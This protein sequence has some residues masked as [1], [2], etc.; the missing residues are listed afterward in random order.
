MKRYI[1]PFEKLEVWQLSLELSKK[2][3]LLTAN[4]SPDER[5]G[6]V[7]QIRRAAN[8]VGA[9]IAEGATRLS[10]K[11]RARFLEIA[12]GS[13]MEV[14][15]FLFLSEGLKLVEKDNAVE[16]FTLIEKLSN[17]M[18]AFHK[19]ILSAVEEK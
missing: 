8:S 6:I 7:R 13:L 11:D 2:V 1:F 3:Y 15:H 9:N 17:K 10:P 5:Y 4:Y 19:K 12:F 16:I 14:T 18:N